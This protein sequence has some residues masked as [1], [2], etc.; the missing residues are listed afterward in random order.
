MLTVTLKDDT[1]VKHK[2]MDWET[3]KEDVW[4]DIEKYNEKHSDAPMEVDLIAASD[5]SIWV[6]LIP[7]AILVIALV[8]FWIFIMKRMGSGGMGS[9]ELNFG[10]AKFKNSAD[11]KKK[12]T[13]DDVA[14]ADE[15]KEELEEIVEFLKSP[16][17]YNTLGARIPKGVLLVGPPGTGKTLLA[18]AVAG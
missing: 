7:T 17:K 9:K 13:F 6:E 18:K 1:V 2:L 15:E 3:F 10:K 11:E 12:T 14:G 4:D 16:E 8:F 5:S